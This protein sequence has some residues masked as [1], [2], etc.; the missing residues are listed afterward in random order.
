MAMTP[1]KPAPSR[2]APPA[3]ARG[4]GDAG[5]ERTGAVAARI[6]VVDDD[7]GIN[8]LI[9]LRLAAWGF[10]VASAADGDEALA[11]IEREPPDLVI[12]DVSMPGR[13][14]LDVLAAIR[15]Q[16][17][18]VAVVMTTAFGSEQIAVEALR[19]GADD[20]IRKPFEA[21][22]L[23]AVVRRA[24]ARLQLTRQNA[25]LRAQ[26]DAKRRELE[27]ELVRAAKVQSD[28]LPD[29][30]P[31]LPGFELAARC[32]PARAVGG[33]FYDWYPAGN[34]GL[35]LTLGDVMGKGMPAALLMA[36]ARAALRTAGAEH[37][38]AAA[39]TLVERAL[40]HDFARSGSFLTLFHAHLDA[41]A[42]RLRFVDAGHGYAVVRRTTGLE[43]LGPRGL[44]LGA[45]PA[46]PYQEGTIALGRGDALVLY[47][48]GLVDQLGTA[49][50]GPREIASALADAADAGSVVQRLTSLVADDR[51]LPDDMTVVVLRRL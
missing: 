24:V 25:A 21:A 5:V 2:E 48:D 12:L 44:P 30:P 8:R 45:W 13:G 37:P 50:I 20:Y 31:P 41:A 40:R 7:P 33:D 42:S 38:P 39:V 16:G 17:L 1:T 27:A 18:D 22:D 9:S 51:A 34:G 29:Q 6:L 15:D 19:R 36:T 28:L 46:A 14:G 10:P 43:A 4:G 3:N 49:P 47:T 26:L 11:V 23:E 35:T 32:V